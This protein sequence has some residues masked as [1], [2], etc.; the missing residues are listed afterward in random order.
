ME[1]T[2][3]INTYDPTR[4]INVVGIVVVVGLLIALGW[5]Y[6]IWCIPS[7]AGGVRA[8]NWYYTTLCVPSIGGVQ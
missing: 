7:L 6:T 4:V 5:Y 8:V 2:K 3:C 1:D